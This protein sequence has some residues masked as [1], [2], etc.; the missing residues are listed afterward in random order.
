MKTA[1]YDQHIAL[2][3][4]MVEFAGW[5]MPI[6]YSGII[7]EHHAVRQHAGLFDVS[8]MGRILIEGPDAEKLLDFL[9]TNVIAGKPS[10]SATYTVW[11]REDGGCVDDVIVYK[12]DQTHYFVIVN[13]GNRDKDYRHLMKYAHGYDVTVNE[14]FTQDGILAIQGPA[15]K[16]ILKRLFPEI[17]SIAPMH[18]KVGRYHFQ[19]AILSATG[20]TGAG[21]FEIYAPNTAIT[22]LW[23]DLLGLGKADGLIPV[24][25]GARDTLRLEM[26]YALYGHELKEDIKPIETVSH[27]TVKANKH[28]FLG[29]EFQEKKRTQH[30]LIVLEGGIAREGYEVF[31]GD[32]SIGH[33]T[34]GT[35]SPTL[36]K[37]VAIILSTTPLNEGDIVDVQIRQKRC[38]CKIVKLPFITPA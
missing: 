28:D 19:E 20:Y 29:K 24:G 14:R 4:K 16:D 26:G 32:A 3:A 30:G 25:L 38:P 13:A 23:K 34:S 6:Q 8:H 11:C 10:G 18:F 9:S 12:V 21:G 36:Q 5:E 31:K 7:P 15:A 37:A 33:V 35:F 17:V 22:A 1:L 27:W 2:G